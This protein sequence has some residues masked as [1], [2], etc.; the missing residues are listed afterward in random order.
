[1]TMSIAK[2][3]PRSVFI[4]ACVLVALCYLNSLPN[5]LIFDDGPIVASNPAIRS[6]SPIQFLKSP[7]WTQQ[8]YLGIYRPFTVFSLS[9]D[10]ALW[11]RWAPGFRI[12]NLLLHAVN[13]F[14]LFLLCT[15]LV[16]EGLVPIA[17][18]IIYLAHPVQTEAV[19]SIVGR[20][21]LFAACFFL[22]AWLL[23]RRGHTL[24]PALLFF[25]AMLSKENA[26]VLPAVLLLD[27]ALTGLREPPPAMMSRY[28]IM[29]SVALAYLALRFFV[30]GGLG[31]PTA[32]QYMGG[33]L[34]YIER[35]MTSGRVF[36]EYL[37]LIFFPLNLAG[38][39]DFN[40]IPIAHLRNWDAWL[41]LF[42][43]VAIVVGTCV[44]QR[45]NKVVA[46]GIL[47]AFLVFIPASNWIT[48][49]SVLM[50]ERFLYL[51][52]IGLSIVAAF[53]FSGIHEKNVQR[54][55][56]IGG[57]LTLI[58]LCNSHDY[59]RR[60]DFTFFKNM[61]RIEPNSAK[62]RLGYG[63]ALLQAGFKDD[64]AQQFEA[65]LRIIP[66]YP[67]LLT[68]LAMTKMTS[69][70]CDEAWPLL[71]RALQVSPSHA[72]T[73]R[74]M[75]D[76]YYKEGK[77]AEAEAMYRQAV[78]GIAYPD[79]MLYFMWG[80]S[81]EDKGDVRSAI[82]AYERAALIDPGNMLIKQKLSSLKP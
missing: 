70:S 39:Y 64:A 76:C 8:Q 19:T 63:Y 22:A 67:E 27:E 66:D 81:L 75:G 16:G 4:V 74:R 65:G 18:M 7:Y 77:T 9:V 20:S 78:E 33:H 48:P 52:L 56:G 73:H 54:W 49:I 30:L 71:R 72:D 5:D 60:N 36:I 1:M 45:R 24:L 28:S 82:T 62:A 80:R 58:V 2:L 17:A 29:S 6:I 12:T 57:L 44:Y 23:F 26:I 31:I 40:A 15:S 41:G 55:I 61:V 37:R 21:E 11:Q 51:P 59:V 14:L 3:S 68:T 32:A 53:V 69:T 46:L 79:S 38:D 47:F 50:A 34:T 10:Y 43:I 42:L 25:L 13:G 35:V